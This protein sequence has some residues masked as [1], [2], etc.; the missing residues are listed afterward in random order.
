MTWQ[1]GEGDGKIRAWVDRAL[2]PSALG[3]E[4]HPEI[5]GVT[6]VLVARAIEANVK[7]VVLRGKKTDFGGGNM[8][9][10][11]DEMR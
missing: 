1:F 4:V 11:D 10:R 9:T 5:I 8:M 3:V 2:E 7:T 6:T